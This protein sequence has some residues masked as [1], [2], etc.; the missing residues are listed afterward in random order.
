M[1]IEEWMKNPGKKG[2]SFVKKW[3][4]KELKELSDGVYC[5]YYFDDDRY[6]ITCRAFWESDD[7]AI[8]SNCKISTDSEKLIHKKIAEIMNSS[9]GEH[10][11]DL[12]KTSESWKQ[13]D[14]RIKFCCKVANTLESIDE[15]YSWFDTMKAAGV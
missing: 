7:Y 1:T 8:I 12:F 3:L 14:A 6:K 11:A 2:R 4:V 9:G 5:C 10:V 13:V 15:N